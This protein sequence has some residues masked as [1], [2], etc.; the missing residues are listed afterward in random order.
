MKIFVLLFN[1]NLGFGFGWGEYVDDRYL[2]INRS[3][4]RKKDQFVGSVN[5]VLSIIQKN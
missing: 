4:K 2:K 3:I 1:E 5:E